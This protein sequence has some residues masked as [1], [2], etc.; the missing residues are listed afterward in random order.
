MFALVYLTLLLLP[1]YALARIFDY[2]RPRFLF[3]IALSIMF[4]VVAMLVA[5]RFQANTQSYVILW[6]L[7]F[8]PVAVVWIVLEARRGVAV[9]IA[10]VLAG[11]TFSTWTAIVLGI[12]VAS[13]AYW[14][15][16]Y[17]EIPSDPIWHLAQ[18]REAYEDVATGNK[19]DYD[20][21]SLLFSKSQQYWYMLV[22]QSIWVSGQEVDD[23][24]PWVG[25]VNSVLIVIAFYWFSIEVLR[26]VVKQEC[27]LAVM[28]AA[29]SLFF[30]FHFG[31]GAFSF[32]RYY[33]LGPVYLNYVVYM[34]GLLSVWRYLAGAAVVDRWLSFAVIAAIIMAVLHKQETLFL[35]TMGIAIT[36]IYGWRIV[37]KQPVTEFSAHGKILLIAGLVAFAYLA[38]HAYLYVNAVRHN[39]LLHGWM[40][41][42]GALLPFL[43]NLYIL[44]PHYQFYQVLTV[45]GALVYLLYFLGGREIRK[46]P[47]I[48]A[49]MVVPIL[50]V[51]N[52]LFTD[53][54]LRVS[55]PEVL[56]RVTLVVPLEIVG[57]Y[58]LVRS[59]QSSVSGT[60]L[61]RGRSAIVAVLLVFTL[62]PF[63]GR[64]VIN[65]YSKLEMLKP[66]SA[67]NDA[68]Y[69][70]ELFG[71]LNKMEDNQV[72][73]D[74]VTG[75]ST[76]AYTNHNYPAHKFYGRGIL[77]LRKPRYTRRDF[78]SYR[79]WLLVV[80]RKDGARSKIG[81]SGR[82]WSQNAMKTSLFYG[83]AFLQFVSENPDLFQ[84]LWSG[85]EQVIYRIA[86]H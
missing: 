66:V 72:L 61:D 10:D 15:G 77:D 69:W 17:V 30:V 29:S 4:A 9:S 16:P 8:S 41:D 5:Q 68:R 44:K 59:I 45:W 37:R 79:G 67:S 82:H 12:C 39:P 6:G 42:I 21:F 46:S 38:V 24:L 50:T 33:T 2:D 22:G 25:G 13:Y 35:L 53:L 20:K 76:N 3:A 27:V 55:Y 18:I 63:D 32:F 36:L 60:V 14:A 11:I 86:K 58:F 73:T 65:E 54:F 28:A 85:E 1:G 78:D 56:W 71:R 31:L 74:P 62:F 83:D 19:L 26:P 75:Y 70:S 64:F 47:V 43:Q 52:P 80:N 7:L 48:V 49:G 40:T 23:T 81:Q 84:T 34:A 57:S 51:F